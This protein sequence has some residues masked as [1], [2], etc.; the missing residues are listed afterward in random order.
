MMTI[1]C[2]GITAVDEEEE[3]VKGD[4]TLQILTSMI[5]MHLKKIITMLHIHPCHQ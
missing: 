2:V 4:H 5:T 3:E 1:S